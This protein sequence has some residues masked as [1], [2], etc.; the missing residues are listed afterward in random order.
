M[1]RILVGKNE[2]VLNEESFKN[3][4]HGFKNIYVDIGTGSGT[5][6]YKKAIKNPDIFFI[7]MDPVKENMIEISSKAQK[8]YKKIHNILFI[9]SAIENIPSFIADEVT[10]Y[11]PWGILLEAIVKP[12]E[13]MMQKI[14][15][16]AK[17]NASFDFITT[18]SE[19]FDGNQIKNRE[20]PEINLEYFGKEEYSEKL[21]KMGL[22]MQHIYELSNNELK[23]FNSQW[24]KKLAFGKSRLFF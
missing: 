17:D 14:I 24:A 21:K 1:I 19:D 12:I 22:I 6:V 2:E 15:Y 11:F 5:Y 9:I 13:S 20:L 18:Y 10:V 4:I 8:K 16:I 23:N 3:I 7:G